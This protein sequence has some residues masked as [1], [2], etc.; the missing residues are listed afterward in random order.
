MALFALG[1][2]HLSFG[3]Q[4]PMD[5]FQGWQ[6][7]ALR[8][9]E[10]WRKTVSDSDTVVLPG[11]ISWAMNFTE[12]LP[13][14]QFLQSLPGKKI[15]SKGNHDYWWATR[16]KLDQFLLANGLDTI[17]F[18]HNNCI[19]AEGFRICG[20]RGWLFEN[21]QPH[22][23]KVLAREAGRL[24]M[25]LEAAKDKEGELIV[26]LHYPPV[27]AQE[28]NRPVISVLQEYGV[29]RVFSGHI[30]GGGCQYAVNGTYLDMEFRM[31]SGDHL[32]FMPYRIENREETAKSEE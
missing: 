6:D 22:D 8:M 10:N 1:D 19:C 12:A 18:L 14:F 30:H 20:T 2:P 24:R 28:V 23:D 16:N 29:K 26:F 21:G 5:I 7:H 4:K 32:K 27:F 25:S 11:D 17:E 9:E 31:V 13:D 3:C 15:I